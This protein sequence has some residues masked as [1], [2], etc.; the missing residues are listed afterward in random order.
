GLRQPIWKTIALALRNA[1]LHPVPLPIIA[2]LLFSLTG[3]TLPAPIDKT[4]QLLG[5]A[6]APIA[7]VLVGVTLAHTKVGAHLRGALLLA[8]VKNLLMPLLVYLFGR[9]L[10][11]SGL[12]LAVMIVAAAMPSGANV[13][14][15]SQRYRVAEE[16]STATVAV[17][18]VMALV[19]V[20]V[21]L[22]A[23]GMI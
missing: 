18:T 4:L 22:A 5:Q 13:F 9:L 14:L 21:V 8:T 7:L 16:L 10:G 23:V 1:V 15:F 12:P 17:S 3:L 2:G 19:T 6:F 11:V 20:S